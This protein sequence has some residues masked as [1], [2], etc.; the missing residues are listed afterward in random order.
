MSINGKR[1]TNTFIRKHLFLYW[2]LRKR[3]RESEAIAP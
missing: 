2:D 3:E 1:N